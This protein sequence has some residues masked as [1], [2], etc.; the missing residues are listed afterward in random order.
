MDGEQTVNLTQRL[1]AFERAWVDLPVPDI[2][3]FLTGVGDEDARVALLLE[4]I[5]IDLE[6]RWKPKPAGQ[7]ETVSAAAVPA[8][9]P[10]KIENYLQRFSELGTVADVSVE[11][12][13]N[14]FRVRQCWADRPDVAEYLIRFPGRDSLIERVLR[15]VLQQMPSVSSDGEQTIDLTI[16]EGLQ[17]ADLL[18]IL[19]EE[20]LIPAPVLDEIQIEAAN[21]SDASPL[22]GRELLERR[23]LTTWQMQRIQQRQTDRLRLGDYLIV[24]EL[25]AGGM[26]VVYK[27][28]HRRMRRVVALK[29]LPRDAVQSTE[30]VRRFQQ[31]VRVIAQLTHRNVVTAF[32]AGDDNGVHYLVMEYVEGVDLREHVKQHGPLPLLETLRCVIHA[33]RGLGYAHD[34]GIVHR[35]VK[36]SNLLLTSAQT[37]KVLDLGLARMDESQRDPISGS[38]H[39][40]ITSPGSLMGTAEYMAPEQANDTRKADARADVYSLGCTL[41]YLLTGAPP[42]RGESVMETLLAHHQM[43]IPSLR[44]TRGDVPVMLEAVFQRMLAKHPDHRPQSMDEV[45]ELLQAVRSQCLAA[46]SEKDRIDLINHP[47][48]TLDATID[49]THSAVV[50]SP[51]S[52][53]G[54]A[55][56]SASLP[57]ILQEQQHR[58]ELWKQ[59]E[60]FRRTIFTLGAMAM[61]IVLGL[62]FA[63]RSF[64]QT[65]IAIDWPESER[66]GG[67]IEINGRANPVPKT[68][69]VVITGRPGHRRIALK[70]TGYEDIA[71]EFT[72]LSGESRSL[73]PDWLPTLESLSSGALTALSV[74]IDDFLKATVGKPANDRNELAEL[75]LQWLNL[76]RKSDVSAVRRQAEIELRRL[77]A[78]ADG[79]PAGQ[80][81][82]YERRI[83][84]ER[85]A[86]AG[87]RLVAVL[88]DSRLH[89]WDSTLC[90]KFT[91][92]GGLITGSHDGSVVAWDLTTGEIRWTVATG[93]GVRSLA[94][95]SAG[96]VAVGVYQ[97]GEPVTLYDSETGK[98]RTEIPQQSGEIAMA[99][100]FTPDDRLIVGTMTQVGIWNETDHLWER[101]L[102]NGAAR[103]RLSPSGTWL[104][105]SRSDFGFQTVNLQT[106]EVGVAVD[107]TY[108]YSV[109]FADDET[110]LAAVGGDIVEWNL[111]T[112]EESNLSGPTA[113]RIAVNPRDRNSMVYAT[114]G[115]YGMYDS[116]TG[117]TKK[118]QASSSLVQAINLEF[119][120]DGSRICACGARGEILVWEA[121]TS[122]LL[123]AVLR[124]TGHRGPAYKVRI[125]PDGN[126]AVSTGHDGTIRFWNLQTGEESVPAVSTGAKS[127]H[128]QPVFALAI[129]HS[130]ERVAAGGATSSAVLLI[131]V[132]KKSVIDRLSK[133]R[134]CEAL[135]FGP[136]D[137][138]VYVG[139][140]AAVTA[141][142]VNTGSVTRDAIRYRDG[143]K[144]GVNSIVISPDGKTLATSVRAA[145]P[146]DEALRFW[147]RKDFKP[148]RGAAGTAPA[149][150]LRDGRLLFTTSNASVLETLSPNAAD[151]F[152]RRPRTLKMHTHGPD[153]YSPGATAAAQNPSDNSVVTGYSDGVI[154]LWNAKLEHQETIRVG[155]PQGS[156]N[157]IA[158][159][160]DG[161]HLITANGNGTLYV[162]RL[163]EWS[164]QSPSPAKEKRPKREMQ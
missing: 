146:P 24:D 131:D 72:L 27:A 63:W 114:E 35:D 109:E 96:E 77:P 73:Q 19:R 145:I 3:A 21:E 97:K 90:A 102:D 135:A 14:E 150:F 9:E 70:R 126:T 5:P 106:R 57:T 120:T 2:A 52:P 47:D 7:D 85:Y 86:T 125:T 137:E 163:S 20:E 151:S 121:A 142:N 40:Q 157:D 66:T 30:N 76:Y 17:N 69:P 62:F 13:Q 154:S 60:R 79:L 156:I 16:A 54:A 100:A 49:V 18:R 26:G 133:T 122:K 123:P 91:P 34:Q 162:L 74:S 132:A 43:P 161:R 92:A 139:E 98:P 129:G 110:V 99:L 68:G 103:L 105:A 104:A 147:G 59:R 6:L 83:L 108:C 113:G 119:S 71:T 159:T 31:E 95:S 160:P 56:A 53:L 141:W 50:G 130:G 37:V 78:P 41:Y 134:D 58:A 55:L 11:L 112:G 138:V 116:K 38:E 88:G 32:D 124:P 115:T 10:W 28:V 51:V 81:L 75:R 87:D 118:M 155:P 80:D 46:P 93:Y 22:L 101:L 158:F 29:V 4:L 61:L 8:A 149:I 117:L 111:K 128:Q 82:E 148:G 64:T 42:F 67:I 89:H 44:D 84:N 153:R 15:D 48:L 33:A 65:T 144:Y 152:L 140:H 94:V 164:N 1:E 127:Y 45:V 36:P 136:G 143:T 12:I 25:G 107:R 23:L 39:S